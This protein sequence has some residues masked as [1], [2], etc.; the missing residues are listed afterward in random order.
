MNA[1]VTWLT[2]E[3]TIYQPA[4]QWNNV[5]GIYIFAG[6]NLHNQWVPYYI[7]QCDSFQNRIP[8]H[9]QWDRARSL[10]ATH[11]HAR[12]VPPVATRIAIEAELILAYQP[13]LNTQLK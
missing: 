9:E 10:G 11:V 5:S 2:Y 1:T 4:T 7:G 12:A 13:W 3:F 6:L 8:S